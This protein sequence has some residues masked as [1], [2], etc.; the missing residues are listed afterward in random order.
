MK[1]D[2]VEA[3]W[4]EQVFIWVRPA[5][6]LTWTEFHG[7][8][9][10]NRNNRDWQPA[11]LDGFVEPDRRGQYNTALDSRRVTLIGETSGYDVTAFE[12]GELINAP[13]AS[14]DDELQEAQSPRM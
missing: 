4:N 8:T 3:T 10:G 2:D 13:Q 7:S 1:I 6:E 11:R 14:P 9:F 12:F 5:K